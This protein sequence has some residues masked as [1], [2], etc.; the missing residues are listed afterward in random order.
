MSDQDA[1]GWS[2][3]LSTFTLDESEGPGRRR[4]SR[5]TR[6]SPAVVVMF[7]GEPTDFLVLQRTATEADAQRA[8]ADVQAAIAAADADGAFTLRSSV[9]FFHMRPDEG[10]ALQVVE[11]VPPEEEPEP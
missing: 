8:L 4:S 3:A 2:C 1:T 11:H 10:G 5:E 6:R 9:P 7:D